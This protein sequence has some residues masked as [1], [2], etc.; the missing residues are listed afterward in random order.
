MIPYWHAVLQWYHTTVLIQQWY[1]TIAVTCS[2]TI[3]Q[4]WHALSTLWYMYHD[5]TACRQWHGISCQ[6]SHAVVSWYSADMQWY[7]GAVVPWYSV[8]TQWYHGTVLTCS[9]TM[10]V[11]PH[12]HQVRTCQHCACSMVLCLCYCMPMLWSSTTACTCQQCGV[13]ANTRYQHCGMVASLHVNTVTV[14]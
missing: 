12:I 7:H 13:V 5:T 14:A 2:G 8:D 1:H 3:L 11:M 6:Y 9:G 10:L 4:Q